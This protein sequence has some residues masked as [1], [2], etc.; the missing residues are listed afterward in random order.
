[1]DPIFVICF[2]AFLGMALTGCLLARPGEAVAEGRENGAYYRD[3]LESA[4]DMIQSVTPEGTFVYV[5]PPW[6]RV[7]GYGEEEVVDLS[8]F[9]LIHPE[10]QWEYEQMFERVKSGER[11]DRFETVLLTR[12]GR[13]L[14]VEGSCSC[15]LK[16]DAP[17][18]IL[19]IFR[20]ITQRKRAEEMLAGQATE[21][22]R[23]HEILDE[24]D[25]QLVDTL[26]Q[27]R[28]YREAQER[29][30]ELSRI[31][32]ELK[33]E[34]V[35][36]VEAEK[37]ITASLREKEVLLKEIH[38]R[39]K[40][41]LQIITSLLNLQSGYIDDP[42]ALDMFR[43]SQDRIRTMAL[44]HEKLYQSE[45]LAKVDFSE[46]IQGLVGYLSRSYA[47]R[48][49]AVRMEVNVEDV[50][51]GIDTAIPCGLI[52]NE[53]VS[54]ALKYAFSESG[55]GEIRIALRADEEGELTLVVGDD[56]VGFPEDI[57]FRETE[58]LGLQLVVTLIDQL[59]GAIELD[60]NGGT[61]FTMT[62][63]A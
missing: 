26:E 8:L 28:K 22:L 56:G 47:T 3:L 24:K 60:R 13:W 59:E 39:V 44:I 63:A 41:N 10:H 53:L 14:T 32:E 1:M 57:D 9:D 37:Q 43:E 46:Y 17:E 33:A 25:R 7:L 16:E 15:I 54:N 20:D 23:V 50:F 45:D 38:H 42:Q 49:G 36:R 27:T 30:R 19:S 11:V 5:N 61:T 52:I 21:M 62:F 48:A 18:A 4:G 58:S 34:I 40:N 31:N 55:G 6:Q 51:L 2:G 12:E 29:A 35:R